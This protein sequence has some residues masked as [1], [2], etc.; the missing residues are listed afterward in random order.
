MQ[1]KNKKILIT[2]GAGFLGRHVIAKLQSEGINVLEYINEP[3]TNCAYFIRSQRYDLT[4]VNVTNNLIEKMKPDI[5]I[6]LAAAVGGI[7]IN[8]DN[9]GTFY[10]KNLM[11]GTN[12]IEAAKNNHIKKFIQ[13]GTVC[14]YPINPP[15]PFKEDDLWNGY[16]EPTN[17]SYGIAKKAL[18]IQLQAYRSEFGLNGI[19][20][21]PTNLYGP[22]DNFD[23]YSSH[24]IPALIRKCI[25]ARD[26]NLDHIECWGTGEA[27]R[28][29][30][31][32]NDAAEAI[33]LAAKSYDSPEPV[34][35]G[36]G[37]DIKIKDLV[38]LIA[39]LT[40]YDGNI[41][42]N[43]SYPDGQ[44]KRQLDTSRAEKLFGFKAT[45]RLEDGLRSTIDYYEQHFNSG[46]TR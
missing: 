39:E 27:T 31:Y 15:Y 2:G 33:I 38:S 46:I 16:P 10:Y 1:L 4:N 9:P 35:I 17:A 13:I 23:L 19:Y 6:H 3:S 5:I 22:Y 21:I 29:F 40:R 42:W 26:N 7:G 28:E 36:S 43:D 11:M 25:T 41:I 14:S 37:S 8:R 32:V 24:V 12:L 45:T 18:L 44:P 34:N 30:L 20:L